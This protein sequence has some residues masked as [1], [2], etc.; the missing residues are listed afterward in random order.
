MSS[1]G[2]IIICGSGA[3]PV[4]DKTIV[5]YDAP[6]SVAIKIDKQAL[7]DQAVAGGLAPSKAIER[8]E[9]LAQKVEANWNDWAEFIEDKLGLPYTRHTP[10]AQP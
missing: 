2:T 4:T 9:R 10:H 3:L 1:G 8:V 6:F 5:V 7:Y